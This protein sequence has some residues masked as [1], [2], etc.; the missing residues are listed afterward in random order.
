MTSSIQAEI[1]DGFRYLSA[2]DKVRR[3]N[4]LESAVVNLTGEWLE[5]MFQDAIHVDF[6]YKSFDEF[7]DKELSIGSRTARERRISFKKT[8]RQNGKIADTPES[9]LKHIP[10]ED[11][12]EFK[13]LSQYE[14]DKAIE[15]VEY[16]GAKKYWYLHELPTELIDGFKD[17]EYDIST[18]DEV[19]MMGD[20]LKT[21][22][23]K[24]NKANEMKALKNKLELNISAKVGE[25]K[26]LHDKTHTKIEVSNV[27]VSE[28]YHTLVQEVFNGDYERVYNGI[29]SAEA[30]RKRN[31]QNTRGTK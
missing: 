19:V 30:N 4:E 27:R 26:L 23:Q 1:A 14:Q 31:E 10:K 29:K 18:L 13:S 22:T 6:G 3:F 2:E 20:K 16:L 21:P 17:K 9:K 25:K 12:T 15:T 8:L 28:A 11:W 24:I 5:Q 7:V